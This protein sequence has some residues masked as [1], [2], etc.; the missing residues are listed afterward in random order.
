L[1]GDGK[2]SVFHVLEDGRL[3]LAI[4]S[5]EYWNGTFPSYWEEKDAGARVPADVVRTA[6]A[7]RLFPERFAGI[8]HR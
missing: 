2:D 4:G 6:F 8:I 5:E 7:E 3:Q 1:A